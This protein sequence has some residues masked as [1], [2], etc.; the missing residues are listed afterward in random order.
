VV[1]CVKYRVLIDVNWQEHQALVTHLAVVIDGSI[2]QPYLALYL[3]LIEEMNREAVC[4]ESGVE[5]L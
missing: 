2:K 5:R 3:L 1:G 4:L